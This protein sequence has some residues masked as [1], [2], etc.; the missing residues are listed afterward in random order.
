MKPILVTRGP[1][2]RLQKWFSYFKLRQSRFYDIYI[3]LL[4]ETQQQ[5]KMDDETLKFIRHKRP[6]MQSK[7]KRHVYDADRATGRS[8]FRRKAIRRRLRRLT[9]KTNKRLGRYELHRN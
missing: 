9:R 7:G 8:G 2:V 4:T 1:A 5:T 6:H 3:S